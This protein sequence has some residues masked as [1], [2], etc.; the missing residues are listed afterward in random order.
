MF[1]MQVFYI[2]SSFHILVDILAHICI[3]DTAG[4]NQQNISSWTF[5]FC[6]FN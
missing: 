4:M 3:V 1:E 5:Y 6:F 2:D